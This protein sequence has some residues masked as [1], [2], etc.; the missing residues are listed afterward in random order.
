MHGLSGFTDQDV[1][2][3]FRKGKRRGVISPTIIETYNAKTRTTAFKSEEEE[4]PNYGKAVGMNANQW[5]AN[6]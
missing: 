2:A 4:H 3:S 6:V 5:W 1:D